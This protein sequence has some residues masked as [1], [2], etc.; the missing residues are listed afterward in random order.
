MDVCPSADHGGKVTSSAQKGSEPERRGH[1]DRAAMKSALASQEG[2][3]EGESPNSLASLLLNCDLDTA[4]AESSWEEDM[5][6]KQATSSLSRIE[7][8]DEELRD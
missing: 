3:Q 8:P 5:E 2:S 1:L 6:P 4:L 7:V